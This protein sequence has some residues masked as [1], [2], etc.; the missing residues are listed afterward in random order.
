MRILVGY[1]MRSGS[2]L[3]QHILDQHSEVRA[4]SDVSSLPSLAAAWLGL[5]KRGYR[6]IKPVDLLYL[7][8]GSRQYRGFDRY[9][10][11]ARDPRDSYLSAVESGYAYLFWPRGKKEE[12]IDVGLLK[13][14]KQIARRYLAQPGQWHLVRYEDLVRDPDRTLTALLDYLVLPPEQLLPFSRFNLLNGGDYKLRSTTTVTSTSLHR[15]A[16]QLTP[17]Q[18]EVFSRY[19]GPELEA[20]GYA[21]VF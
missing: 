19:L 2:T 15:H 21:P 18:Q 7:L 1:S 11:L 3:L 5:R 6:L 16:R 17:G 14:W 12:G 10:W 9:V 4:C 20:F 8:P 13:R